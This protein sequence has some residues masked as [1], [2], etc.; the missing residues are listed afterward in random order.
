MVHKCGAEEAAKKKRGETCQDQS[1]G[2]EFAACLK[3]ADLDRSTFNR[4]QIALS[5]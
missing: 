1:N 2:E 5:S 4:N 3:E